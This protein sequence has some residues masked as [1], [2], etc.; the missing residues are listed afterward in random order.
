MALMAVRSGTGRPVRL[1]VSEAEALLNRLD[2]TSRTKL[3]GDTTER[4]TLLHAIGKLVAV[5]HG[6]EEE[7]AS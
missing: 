7:K 4:E 6:P 3:R 2:T 1:S 5:V